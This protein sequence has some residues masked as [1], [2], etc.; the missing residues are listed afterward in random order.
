MEVVGEV[1]NPLIVYL[2]FEEKVVS[3]LA[4]AALHSTFYD[5]CNGVASKPVTKFYLYPAPEELKKE[6]YYSK[7]SSI[8]VFTEEVESAFKKMMNGKAAGNVRVELLTFA[9]SDQ[10]NS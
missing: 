3:L 2:L 1:A 10:G 4:L 6:I 5:L 8:E 7:E 9:E